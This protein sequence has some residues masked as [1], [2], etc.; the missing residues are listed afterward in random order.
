[1]SKK[2]TYLK[3]PKLGRF[4]FDAVFSAQHRFT[5]TLTKHP[6]QN[7]ASISDHAY[8]EPSEVMIDIGMTDTMKGHSKNHSVNAFKTLKTMMSLRQPVKLV[9]RLNTYTN[10]VITSISVPDD[11][12]TMNTLRSTIIFTKVD[13]VS[14]KVVKVSEK[15]KG[16][17]STKNAKNSA[18]NPTASKSTKSSEKVENKSTLKKLAEKVTGKG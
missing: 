16:S 18:K 10:M 8:M 12:K 3:H 11:V 17:K 4:Y 7:G 5:V 1:M 15:I 9:T 6:V 14:V 13:L 2:T